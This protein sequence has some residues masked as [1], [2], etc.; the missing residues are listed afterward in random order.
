MKINRDYS[1]I[2]HDGEY[3][4]ASNNDEEMKFQQRLQNSSETAYSI[5]KDN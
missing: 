4:N 3:I 2:R 1:F 5:S